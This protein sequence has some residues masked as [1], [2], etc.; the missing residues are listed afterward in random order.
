MSFF[1]SFWPHL[2][3]MEVP[4]PGIELGLWLWPT[5][6]PWQ[7]WIQVASATYAAA[8]GSVDPSHIFNLYHSSRQCWILNPLSHAR[9]KPAFSQRQHC[10]LN[11]PS[12]SRNSSTQYQ[13]NNM[14]KKGAEELNRH[15]SKEDIQYM[16]K[17]SALLIIREIQISTT[18]RYTFSKWLLSNSQR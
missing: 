5:P 3:H 18:I 17:C 16:K 15:F 10:V 13:N 12:H 6:Q 2:R 7:H 4:G 1:F 8:Y 14:I 9:I 11:P